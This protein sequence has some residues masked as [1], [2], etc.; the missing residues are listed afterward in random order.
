MLLVAAI[1][2]CHQAPYRAASLPA[3]FA[4]P[5]NLGTHDLDLAQFARPT[6]MSDLVQVGD[7][8]EVSISTGLEQKFLPKWTLR[9]EDD[10]RLTVPL[11]GPVQ[12]EGLALSEADRAIHR[13]AVERGL[14]RNPN[15][16][17]VL[18]D[19]RQHRI[20]V[21]GA[22]QRPGTYELPVG[23]SDLLSAIVAAGGLT[24]AAGTRVEVR[25]AP[26]YDSGQHDRPVTQL[27]SYRSG[28]AAPPISPP[29]RELDLASARHVE[30]A[31][32]LLG[33]GAVV[34]IREKPSQTVYVLGKVNK[35]GQVDVPDG[36]DLHLLDAIAVA[37]GRTVE[38]ADKVYIV[39]QLPDITEPVMI[40]ASVRAAKSDPAAN[41]RL[42]P[43]DVVSVEETALTFTLETFQRVIRMSLGAPL[44]G[45]F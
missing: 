16:S 14:Y 43:G 33:D 29:V 27:T 34:T 12:L 44:T 1:A 24:D 30:D 4:A 28:Q 2:G 40:Q 11:V 45:F 20:V 38:V 18:K 10:G 23:H 31:D 42:A 22:V 9:V 26:G 25:Q 36:Q 39:R 8:L 21:A 7:V 41:L 37:G 32:V 5:P 15:V 6:A 17:V 19:R 3:E 35:P 13:A